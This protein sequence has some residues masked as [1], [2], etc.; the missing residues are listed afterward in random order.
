MI[1]WGALRSL[2]HQSF[3]PRW[4]QVIDASVILLQDEI[5][6][7]SSPGIS[8]ALAAAEEAPSSASFHQSKQQRFDEGNRSMRTAADESA[9]V[10]SKSTSAAIIHSLRRLQ[11]NAMSEDNSAALVLGVCRL[12]RC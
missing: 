8:T 5:G 3:K 12:S 7:A 1:V 4:D 6:C 2:L 9:G 10:E 11:R